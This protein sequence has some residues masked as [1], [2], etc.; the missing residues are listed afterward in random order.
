MWGS[1]RHGA[2]SNMTRGVNPGGVA[3]CCQ[4]CERKARERGIN[5]DRA[6]AGFRALGELTRGGKRPVDGYYV[7]LWR[8]M[9][10]Y[11]EILAWENL[12]HDSL[13]ETYAAIYAKVKSIKPEVGVGW[14]IWHQNSFTPIYRAEQDLSELAKYSDFLKM[15]MHHN[16]GRERLIGYIRSVGPTT[17]GDVPRPGLLAFRQHG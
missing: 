3:C 5:V 13:R 4:F 12:W 6:R 11:P 16:C 1:E 14:H 9:L 7:T 15:G 8:I 10:R 2:F 17:D